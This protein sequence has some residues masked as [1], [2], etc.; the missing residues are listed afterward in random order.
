MFIFV[1]IKTVHTV[2]LCT[3]LGTC[4][5]YEYALIIVDEAAICFIRVVFVGYEDLTFDFTVCTLMSGCFRARGQLD[6]IDVLTGTG[7]GLLKYQANALSS[8]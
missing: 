3:N 2:L 8:A 1:F 4:M 5:N 6:L 7:F